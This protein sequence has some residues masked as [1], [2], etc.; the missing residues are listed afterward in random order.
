GTRLPAPVARPPRAHLGRPHPV[1]L[2]DG[3]GTRPRRLGSYDPPPTAP[4]APAAWPPAAAPPRPPGPPAPA[5]RR[6]PPGRP[7]PGEPARPP[8]VPP[9]ARPPPRAPGW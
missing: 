3:E 6:E 5:R 9:A 7:R 2:P 1:P 8:P 4:P